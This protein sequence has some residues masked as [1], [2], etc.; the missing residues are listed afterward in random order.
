MAETFI[1][2]EVGNCSVEGTLHR[3][4]LK[5]APLIIFIHGGGLVWGSK[6]DMHKEQIKRYTEAGFNV[7]SVDY[8]L[9]PETKLPEIR[10]DIAYLLKWIKTDA[11]SIFGFDS[12]RVAVIGNSAGGYLAL[13]SGTFD[14][15]PDAIVSFYGYGQIT[16]DWYR[17]ASSHFTAM[18]TVTKS[19]AEQ[20]VQPT[21]IAAAPIHTRYAIYL[22]CRQTG[23]WLDWVAGKKLAE[24]SA[25][26]KKFAPIEL[27]DSNYPATFLIHGNA[28]EDV[29]YA[30][31][32]AMKLKL[33]TA[34]V[35]N[36]LLTIDNGKHNFDA[37][38]SD[39]NA[40]YAVEQTIK[41][42]TDQF[43]TSKM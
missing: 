20:L 42:L 16:G 19:L 24:D 36:E 18:P 27:A 6:D 14:I 9:A 15:K 33:D 4:P 37:N 38:M 1:Y 2:R 43:K 40:I 13:L 10:D 39:P 7:F 23:S 5:H 32:V 11:S 8:R 17:N 22:Y 41:F 25:A 21:P 29:P 30:E 3:S 34:G 12:K 31:S 26:L 35:S 28:D